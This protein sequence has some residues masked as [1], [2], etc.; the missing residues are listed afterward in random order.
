MLVI[1]VTGM[2]GA[3]KEGVVARAVEHGFSVYRMGDVVRDFAEEN[4]IPPQEIGSYASAERERHGR[5]I[6]AYRVL[7]R[8]EKGVE[9]IVIDGCRSDFELAVFHMYFG[10]N[11]HIVAVHS[12]PD[13]RFGRLRKRGR[14][15]API[16][17]EEFDERDRRELDWGL[18]N[19]IAL[20]D[21]MIVNEGTIEEFWYSIDA[22]LERLSPVNSGN[23]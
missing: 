19:V 14:E 6:W 16:S 17:R 5:D 1:V 11:L 23:L 13:T 15:D 20:A 18:G 8:I 7:N 4:G 3:G 10:S 21:H 2:P 9:K 12:S 22:L